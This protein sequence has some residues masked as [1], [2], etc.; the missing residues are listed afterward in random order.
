MPSED[1]TVT[2]LSDH[3]VDAASP[4][5]QHLEDAIGRSK[6]PSLRIRVDTYQ[7][8]FFNLSANVLIDRHDVW[9]DVEAEIHASLTGAFAFESRA[10]RQAVTAAEVI[11]VI[12]GVAGVVFVDL[13]ALYRF[14][15]S[16]S[17]PAHG[18]LAADAVLWEEDK[19]EPTSLSQL[20]VVNPLGIALTP[21]A[22]EAAK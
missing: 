6:D 15:Q 10:F 11:R 4:L 19:P 5:G 1:G 20:L 13:D 7:P 17:L 3:R 14:D 12:Q 22:P 8:V 2:A 18:V 21:I 9:A 16:P